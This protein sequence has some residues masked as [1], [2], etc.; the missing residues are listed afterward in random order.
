MHFNFRPAVNLP[1]FLTSRYLPFVSPAPIQGNKRASK[2]KHGNCPPSYSSH[3]NLNRHLC[4][5]SKP[6]LA[7]VPNAFSNAKEHL[8]QRFD[9]EI[10]DDDS[11]TR[12]LQ[13]EPDA[14]AALSPTISN[15]VSD[16]DELI[17]ALDA[18]NSED[19]RAP[20][21]DTVGDIP[22]QK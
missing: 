21:D 18:E 20:A 17:A 3:P 9:S 13:L 16:I 4:L 10:D 1:A 5:G 11:Q 22:C 14:I 6:T 12:H 2:D 8:Q 19:G 7:G 15:L